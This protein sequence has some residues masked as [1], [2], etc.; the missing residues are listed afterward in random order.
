MRSQI[1]G[2]NWVCTALLDQLDKTTR[3]DICHKQ[4]KQRLCKIITTQVKFYFVDVFQLQ[5]K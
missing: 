3:D 5:V 4:H 2:V 1:F